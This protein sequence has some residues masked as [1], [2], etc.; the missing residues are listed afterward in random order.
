MLKTR[1]LFIKCGH[2]G[3]TGK[4][5]L[6]GIH[7][8]T[9]V[10]LKKQKL[11]ITGVAMSRIAGCT[12]EAMCNRLIYLQELGFAKSERFGVSLLWRVVK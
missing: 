9:L 7:A 1:N 3:G 12:N 11:P 4:R 2:C 5:K 8:E 10:L 6:T